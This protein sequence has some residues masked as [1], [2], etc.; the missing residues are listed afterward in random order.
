MSY[1][2]L[3]N[4]IFIYFLYLNQFILNLVFY[5]RSISFLIAITITL[6]IYFILI[7]RKLTFIKLIFFY[8][9]S[10]KVQLALLL[11]KLLVAFILP[12]FHYFH[13]FLFLPL[14]LQVH[15]Y[16]LIH[17]LDH[18]TFL[19]LTLIIMDHHLLAKDFG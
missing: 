17:N 8:L 7:F 4:F 19:V 15:P 16:L 12:N 6:L 18:L 1:H 5:L 9:Y 3:Q 2:Y 10:K 14:P 11:Y 13:Y